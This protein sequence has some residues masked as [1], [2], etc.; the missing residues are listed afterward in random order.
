[1]ILCLKPLRNNRGPG[2]L[3]TKTDSMVCPK[4]RR[5][6]DP[7]NEEQNSTP[8]TARPDTPFRPKRSGGMIAEHKP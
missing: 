6:Q 7:R 2:S 3:R 8:Q 4:V 5:K 1:M